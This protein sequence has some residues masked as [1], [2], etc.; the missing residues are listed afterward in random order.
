MPGAYGR[1]LTSCSI[2]RYKLRT[3]NRI[4]TSVIDEE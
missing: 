3:E 1:S 4:S 2:L